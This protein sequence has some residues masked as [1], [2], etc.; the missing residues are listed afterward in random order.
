[1]E[2]TDRPILLKL[3]P[4]TSDADRAAVLDLAR[5]AV[6]AGARGLVCSNT[7]AVTEP[8]LATGRGGL[9][10]GPLTELAPR[11]VADVAAA[12]GGSVPI[13]GCGGIFTTADVRRCLDAGAAGGPALHGLDL[14]RAGDRRRAHEGPA[15]G[16]REAACGPPARRPHCTPG[17][18]PSRL[19]GSPRCGNERG[20]RRLAEAA[21]TEETRVETSAAPAAVALD[22]VVKRFGDVVA[23]DGVS[24]DVRPGRVLL[25]PRALRVRQ[26]HLPADDR[27]VRAP[28][29][30]SD[31]PGRP[32]R[33][34]PPTVRAR[35]EHRVPGLR[36]VPAHDGGAERRLRA[37][38]SQAPRERADE[39]RRRRPRDGPPRT[40]R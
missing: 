28:H 35:R 19:P 33:L 9:S 21:R 40:S 8:R 39:S 30:R 7:I 13:V 34:R 23:V 6:D 38:G 4:F 16:L 5:G 37:D 11:I 1:M 26:D 36:P 18:S 31:P 3:P 14:P 32:R 24:L 27:G 10:G 22:Q 12:T 29:V 20:K 15:R 17:P 2:R 25:P